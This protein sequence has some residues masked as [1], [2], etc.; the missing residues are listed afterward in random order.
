MNEVADHYQSIIEKLKAIAV[1]HR[2]QLQ[3]RMKDPESIRNKIFD[4]AQSHQEQGRVFRI[5]NLHDFAGGRL[6]VDRGS[7]LYSMSNSKKHWA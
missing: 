3:F 1:S 6:I 5:S 4:R 2:T 7:A